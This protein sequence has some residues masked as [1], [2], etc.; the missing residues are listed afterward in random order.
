MQAS[1]AHN[2]ACRETNRHTRTRLLQKPFS[3]EVLLREVELVLEG[4]SRQDA[5]AAL[6]DM[7]TPS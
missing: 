7:F 3:A 6:G 5:A 2:N 1:C 4:S